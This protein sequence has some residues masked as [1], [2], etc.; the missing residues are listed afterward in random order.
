MSFDD[1]MTSYPDGKFAI[2]GLVDAPI[3]S[4]SIFERIIY[5]QSIEVYP[6]GSAKRSR[7]STDRRLTSLPTT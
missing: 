4:Q 5:P 2:Y 7:T 3:G 1:Y 6:K